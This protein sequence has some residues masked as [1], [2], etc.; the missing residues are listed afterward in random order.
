MSVTR[1]LCIGLC[2]PMLIGCSSRGSLATPDG[3]PDLF[4]DGWIP[5]DL[6]P[7]PDLPPDAAP[8]PPGCDG[9]AG[10][11]SAKRISPRHAMRVLIG[12]TLD[13][14]LL[15][16][17]LGELFAVALPSGKETKLADGIADVLGPADGPLVVAY[18][19][20][21]TNP[22]RYHL[23]AL[24]ANGSGETPLGSS[25]CDH[26][27]T[28]S[29]HRVLLVQDCSAP[30]GL[31]Q[32]TAALL[33]ATSGKTLWT[34]EGVAAT[35][36]SRIASDGSWAAVVSS[37]LQAP[38]CPFTGTL[39]T[40]DSAGQVHAIASDVVHDSVAF[41]T[42]AAPTRVLF[43]RAISCSS[44]GGFQLQVADVGGS[45]PVT[46][47]TGLDYG[48]TP[49][50]V[51]PDGKRLL[52]AGLGPQINQLIAINTDGGGQTVLA[53]DLYPYHTIAMVY[54]PWSFCKSGAHVVYTPVTAYPEMG[55]AAVPAAGG[56]ILPL[57]STLVQGRYAA[58]PTPGDVWFVDHSS[59]TY[60]LWHALATTG[61]S[62]MRLATENSLDQLSLVPDG[63]GLVVMEQE[64]SQTT[65][66]YVPPSGG[67]SA[68]ALGS[69][70]QTTMQGQPYTMDPGGCVLA[71]DSDQGSPGTYLVLIPR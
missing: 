9:L 63:R 52:A 39:Q 45:T 55:L 33:D 1:R 7:S 62:Q 69:W 58:L 36:S 20:S 37:I 50:A 2:L 14:M 42:P 41:L 23:I 49:Y 10:F 26:R 57:S 70:T 29:G 24:A 35:G 4:F 17:P 67:G 40:I 60:R 12:A 18:R 68:V 59:L 15:L 53:S 8:P 31:D 32:G 34:V 21:L 13:R 43:Q 19:M 25:L 65:L 6:V 47:A 48:P 16:D 51:S 61:A 11:A 71:H 44:P 3:G 28:A 66:R 46:L 54:E 5:P 38:G 30:L 22:G 56:A 64:P 27:M